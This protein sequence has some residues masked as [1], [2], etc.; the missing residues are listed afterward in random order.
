MKNFCF[1]ILKPDALK[2]ELA[3]AILDR[4]IKEGFSIEIIGYKKATEPLIKEHYEEVIQRL[5]QAFEK[6][7]ANGLQNE[8]VLPVILSHKSDDAITIGRKITG[9]TD[10]SKADPGTIRGEFGQD[11]FEL[12]AKEERFCNN[13]IHTC[14]STQ[15]YNK[16][17]N[18]W[19]G[20]NISSKYKV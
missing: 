4:F 17:I 3:D 11:S 18:I 13:L 12:S 6:Q 2:R 8:Y 15:A 1:I 19:F 5:G 14:D 20:K 10:P 16:E 9:A 7:L